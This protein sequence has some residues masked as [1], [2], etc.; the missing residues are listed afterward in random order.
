MSINFPWELGIDE[1]WQCEPDNWL[2]CIYGIEWMW[3]TVEQV[4]REVGP[5]YVM[6][7][8]VLPVEGL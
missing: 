2:E 1:P 6:W 7:F 4:Q 8:D 3:M 5:E